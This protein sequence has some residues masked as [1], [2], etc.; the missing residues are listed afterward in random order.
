MS[1]VIYITL[2]MSI[3]YI[4]SNNIYYGVAANMQT[5]NLAK[6]R[7]FRAQPQTVRWV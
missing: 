1:I 5:C 4:G 7:D 3:E 2:I 6:F